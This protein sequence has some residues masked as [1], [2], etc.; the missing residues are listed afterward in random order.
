MSGSPLRRPRGRPLPTPEATA[1]WTQ[2]PDGGDRSLPVP[3][4]ASETFTLDIDAMTRALVPA[5]SRR[6][7]GADGGADA[8]ISV[9]TPTGE[10]VRFAVTPVEVLADRLQQANSQIRTFAGRGVDDVGLTIRADITPLGFHAMIRSA[11]GRTKAWFVDPATVGDD[12]R[13]VSYAAGASDLPRL[14]EPERGAI[15]E[16]PES[17]PTADVG[18][19][20][21]TVASR[22]VRLALANDPAFASFYGTDNVLA[23]KVSIVNRVA[24]VF[25]ED[26]GVRLVLSEGTDRLNF[27]TDAAATQ[28]GGACGPDACFTPEALRGCEVETLRQNSAAVA[29]I[30]GNDAYDVGHIVLGGGGGS[31]A[32]YGEVGL[33]FVKGG[34][35]TGSATPVG[36]AFA[37]DYVAHEIGHQL[38]ASHTFNACGGS[39]GATAVEPGSGSTIMAY[40]GLCGANDLQTHSDPYLSHATIDEIHRTLDQR[41]PAV[42]TANTA[43]T[44]T[45][46]ASRTIPIR[47]PFALTAEATDAEGPVFLLWEQADVGDGDRALLDDTKI[48]G[49]LFRVF[50]VRADISEADALWLSV[51]SAPLCLFVMGAIAIRFTARN[52]PNRTGTARR[53]RV[54]ESCRTSMVSLLT[55][56]HATWAG[57]G[58][59][60]AAWRLWWSAPVRSPATDPRCGRRRAAPRRP[61]LRRLEDR[62]RRP[63]NR[64]QSRV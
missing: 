4:A 59:S 55:I 8:V 53:D 22:T 24:G 43:P 34:G 49:P 62:H 9:P 12:S 52:V 37:I 18:D 13:H 57:A 15:E 30:V 3:V 23:A 45:A 51:P 2:A 29:G 19:R 27:D 33:D 17:P 6:T 47:T 31:I 60:A 5:V 21:T 42:D 50:G 64:N 26:L 38:G 35:C 39:S 41:L 10:L 46:P 32:G 14:Q 58:R 61:S 20:E 48:A 63:E 44:V 1:V 25:N 56:G 54:A 16:G 7:T 28:P 11:D 36:D 40:A